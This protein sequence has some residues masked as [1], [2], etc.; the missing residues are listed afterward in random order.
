MTA[1]WESYLRA[2]IWGG[3]ARQMFSRLGACVKLTGCDLQM[4]L[5]VVLVCIRR[6]RIWEM[7]YL[8]RFLLHLYFKCICLE[9][10]FP[11]Q[12]LNSV[13]FRAMAKDCSSCFLYFMCL[14]CMFI[15]VLAHQCAALVFLLK[16]T[17]PCVPFVCAFYF[18]WEIFF[19]NK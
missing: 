13:G 6:K 14:T 5:S 10:K 18:D 16:C 3:C 17:C 19:L 2:N 4:D 8:F 15:P 7:S 12:F 1:W 9:H 11:S